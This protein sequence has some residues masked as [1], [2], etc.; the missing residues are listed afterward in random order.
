MS[1]RMLPLRVLSQPVLLRPLEG[2]RR[3]LNRNL[4][5]TWSLKCD[6]E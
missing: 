6:K 1:A 2:G 5:G 4:F 3:V